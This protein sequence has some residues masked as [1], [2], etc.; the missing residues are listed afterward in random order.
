MF[1]RQDFCGGLIGYAPSVVTKP[2]QFSGWL[3]VN[4]AF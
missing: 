3:V 2:S 1:I 4:K